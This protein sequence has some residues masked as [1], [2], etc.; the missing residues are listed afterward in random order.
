MG[1][2]NTALRLHEQVFSTMLRL[3]YASLSIV[4]SKC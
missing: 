3:G 4:V 1:R 2:H